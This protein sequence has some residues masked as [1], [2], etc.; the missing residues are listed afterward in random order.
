[1]APGRDSGVDPRIDTVTPNSGP[2]DTSLALVITAD[3]SLG[4]VLTDAGDVQSVEICGQPAALGILHTSTQVFVTSPVL[5]APASCT[6]TIVSG[7]G[8]VSRSN[9]FVVNP[10]TSV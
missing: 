10:R 7:Y 6:V 5:T 9:A 8:T 4:H 3:S 2:M 1:M